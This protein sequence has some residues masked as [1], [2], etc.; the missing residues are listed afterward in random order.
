M[1]RFSAPISNTNASGVPAQI[2]HGRHG[3]RW[4]A[5]ESGKLPS[6][7]LD[8]SCTRGGRRDHRPV[9]PAELVREL[10]NCNTPLAIRNA[11]PF[12]YPCPESRVSIDERRFFGD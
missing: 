2:F 4:P 3:E 11:E 7:A 6:P 5:P 8:G 12:D 9:P 10:P 1:N